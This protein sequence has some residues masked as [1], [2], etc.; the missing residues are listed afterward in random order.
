M[1]YGN[2]RSALMDWSMW[3]QACMPWLEGLGSGAA[4]STEAAVKVDDSHL[5][6][7]KEPS[8]LVTM[9]VCNRKGRGGRQKLEMRRMT[10][11]VVL[12]SLSCQRSRKEAHMKGTIE[13]LSLHVEGYTC[14][15]LIA[16]KDGDAM[17][18]KKWEAGI[19]SLLLGAQSTT[20]VLT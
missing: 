17:D 9:N 15:R 20:R 12:M 14:E 8:R 2:W 10:K 4:S 16:G 18:M 5:M 11:W 6:K 3:R 19:G 7:Q 13:E 1:T